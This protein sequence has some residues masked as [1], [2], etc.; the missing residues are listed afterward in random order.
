MPNCL[1]MCDY[2]DSG[3]TDECDPERDKQ[4]DHV[5]TGDCPICHPDPDVDYI[6]ELDLIFRDCPTCHSDYGNDYI[7]ELD[8]SDSGVT[9]ECDPERD[10]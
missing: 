4:L 8:Y 1:S 6:D 9:D 5:G 7:D 3:V 10:K 2:S